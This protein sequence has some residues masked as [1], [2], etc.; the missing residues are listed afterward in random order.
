MKKEK[1]VWYRLYFL[2]RKCGQKNEWI[3]DR[4]F[5]WL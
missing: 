2:L 5:T 1:A 4:T 3:F